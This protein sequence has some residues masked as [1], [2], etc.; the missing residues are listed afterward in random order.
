VK[1][2]RCPSC[3][4]SLEIA[5]APSVT[6]RYCGSNVPVPARYRT[7]RPQAAV[8]QVTI[9]L[10]QPY[11]GAAR[12]GQR[13]GCLITLVSLLVVGG[14]G[15]AVL[16]SVQQASEGIGAGFTSIQE[17]RA[18]S[19]TPASTP[20]PAF[21]EEVLEFGGEG[22]GP[23][24]F[25]DPRYIA[26]DMD[27]GIYVA[28]FDDGRVQKFDAE[29]EFVW[30][31]TTPPDDANYNNMAGL[32]VDFK[33]NLYVSRRGDILVLNAEDGELIDTFPGVFAETWY[34]TL[35][36]DANNTLYALHESAGRDD[37]LV[38]DGDGGALA[39]WEKFVSS[40]NRDDPAISLDIAVD[41]QSNVYVSSSFGNQVYVFD[42]SGKFLD[43]FGE[44]GDG[45]GAMNSPGAIAIDGR[46]RVYVVNRAIDVYDARG[47]YLSSIPIDYGKGSIRDLA[48]DI[49]GN[50]Y[51]ITLKGLV[52]KYKATP[53][54]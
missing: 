18:T 22:S 9:D 38:L 53:R 34:T 7:H 31:I 44:E 48:I 51:A 8:Q 40:Q 4:S 24:L 35:A 47:S 45:P 42:K 28:D 43:R 41:G 23:G 10:S 17:P 26:V 37:L 5:D 33:G 32:A 52:L 46:N 39:R 30:Q 29:G 27:G 49:K 13:I 21:A 25:D 2:F 12:G 20:T 11:A 54:G 50:L 15:L 1:A 6:C 19:S 3:G 36:V 14:I 16:A